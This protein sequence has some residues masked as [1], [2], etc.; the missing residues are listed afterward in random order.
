M[1]RAEH[2]IDDRRD[3]LLAAYRRLRQ[4]TVTRELLDVT[5]G[6]EAMRGADDGG[7]DDPGADAEAGAYLRT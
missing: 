2:N 7:G 5:S 6:F 3:A 1:Q 4:E